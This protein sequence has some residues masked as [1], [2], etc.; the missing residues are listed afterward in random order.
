MGI[1]II[2]RISEN[3]SKNPELRAVVDPDGSELSYGQLD[4][5]SRKIAHRLVARGVSKGDF[6]LIVLPRRKEYIAAIWGILLA[7]AA[8]VPQ[9]HDYPK[10]RIDYIRSDCASKITVDEQFLRRIEEEE[11]LTDN[12]ELE[13]DDAG[14]LIYT[15]GSTGK[16][17]GVLHTLDS[18]NDA[19][20]RYDAAVNTYEGYRSGLGAPFTFI[21]SSLNILTGLYAGNTLFVTPLDVVRDPVALADHIEDN[22]IQTIFISPKI[23]KVF[24]PKGNSLELVLTGSERVSNI[25][26]DRFKT[27]VAFGMTEVFAAMLFFIDK[28]YEDTPLGKPLGDMRVYLLDD[29][30][31]RTD[32]GEICLT[33]R[34]AK[35][36][37]HLPE[38]S[39][40]TFTDNPF[41]GED[42][43]PR[44]LRTGD[45]GRYDED[46][47]VIFVNRKDWMVKINGQRVEPGE[48]EA[49]IRE[50]DSIHDVAIKDFVNQY[51]QTY[52]VAYYVEKTPVEPADIR[53]AI[54]E[55]LPSYMVPTF[56]VKLDKLPVNINGKLD[57]QALTA[58]DNS[59]FRNEYVAPE[60]D[61]TRK[62][63]SAME[64][65]LGIDRVGT[66]DD[67]L[68]MG[69]DSITATMV[70][71]KCSGYHVGPADILL[72]K[73]PGQI[74]KRILSQSMHKDRQRSSSVPKIFPLTPAERSMYLEQI[75]DRNNIMYNL[76]IMF[77]F[78]GVDTDTICRSLNEVFAA[79]QSLHS[80]YGEEGGVPVR[81][82]SEKLPEITVSEAGSEEE[83]RAVV[84]SYDVPF[85]LSEEIPVRPMLYK[86]PG[87]RHALHLVIH[88]IAFDGGS[89]KPF[90]A[91]LTAALKGKVLDTGRT[92]LSDLYEELSG[93][94]NEE[95]MEFYRKLFEGGV[96][97]N[98]MP[99][100]GGKRP[101]VHPVSDR[102]VTVVI[103]GDEIKEIDNCARRFSV[104]EFELLFSAVAAVVAKY[105]VSE[106]V[107]LGIPT[108]MRPSDCTDVI[109]MFVNTAPVR[110][111][112]PRDMNV[113][114]YLAGVREAVRQATYGSSLPFEEIVKEFAG[115]KDPSR[116]PLFDVSVNY[117]WSPEAY[118][119]NGIKC[120]MYAPLQ[121]MS[122]DIGVTMHKRREDLTI[123]FQYSTELFEDRVISDLIDQ[124]R[125]VLANFPGMPGAT[126]RSAMQL[127]GNLKAELDK[128]K[129]TALAEVPVTLLHELFEKTAEENSSRTALIAV[130]G[131]WTYSELNDAANRVAKNLI[132]RGVSVGDSVALLLPREKSFFACLIGVNKAGA[133]FIPCDP[134]YPVD[135]ISHIISDS[136]ARFVV[137]TADHIGD[138]PAEQAILVDS[139]LTL[140]DGV[141]CGNPGIQIS[142]DELSYMIYTSGSTGKPKGVMLRH[143]G[144]C[145]YLMPHPANIHMHYLREH[146]NTY[147]SVTTVSFDMSFKEHMA[148]L[149]NGKT[150]V[151]AGE[152]QMNDPRALADLLTKY[153]CDCMNA[154]PSRLLQYIEYQPFCEALKGCKL[155]MSGGEGYPMSLAERLRVIAPSARIINT[156]GPTEITVSCNGADITEAS[157]ITVGRPLLNYSELIVDKFGDI[158]PYGV[159]GELYVGGIGVARGYKNLDDMTRERFVMMDGERMYKTGDLT[160]WTSDGEVEILGRLDNQVKLR[161]LRIELG[162]IEGLLEQ[163]PSIRKAVVVIRKI[164]DQ[165]NLCAYFVSDSEEKIDIQQ[166]RE[167]LKKSL[168]PYMIPTAYLQMKELPLT[169]N[170]KTDIKSL[171]EPEEVV[172]GEYV[173]PVGEIEE[174]FCNLFAEVLRL[175]KVG[176][177]DDFFEIGGT[178]LVVTSIAVRASERGY[179]LNYGDVFKFTT[180]RQLA[181]LFSKDTAVNKNEGSDKTTDFDHYDY[182]AINE[183]LSRNNLTS[184][185]SGKHRDIGNILITGAT[186]FM[187]AHV[188]A[189]FLRNEKGK[190]YCMLRKGGFSDAA[191]RLQNVMFYYFDS[192][193]KELIDERVIVVEGDVTQYE[194]FEIFEKYP[195][196][197]VFNCAANVKHF[198]AGTDIED[199]NVGGVEKCIRFCEKT[200]AR[201][202]HFS[203][204]SVG[205]AQIVPDK[206]DLVLLD[207]Q[208]LYFGQLLDNQY[209]SSKMLAER[210]VLEAVADG[211]VDAK[212][213]R[214]GTLAPRD[215]D[216][217]FQINYLS[218][219][220]MGRLRSFWMLGA[221]PYSSMN[222]VV[223][224]G[225]IDTS[226]SAFF[227]L[228][229]TPSD[230]TVFN[231]INCNST[232]LIN[233]ILEM[234]KIGMNIELMEDE[235]F[236]ATLEQA[237]QDPDKVQVL[238]SLLAYQNKRAEKASYLTEAACVY[239]NQI[240]AREGFFWNITDGPYI[241]RFV[242]SLEALGFFDEDSL[243][244]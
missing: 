109:G 182:T 89:A 111:K 156:Y 204:T 98:D 185:K 198:S 191:S 190:A 229:T 138:Y 71:V 88:H 19:V 179:T 105:T 90:M 107:V 117:M 242:N 240:L 192:S 116:N 22:R 131:E 76:N 92:D 163:Q 81:I 147:L 94:D 244:R 15:S 164:H 222:N 174:F 135:R 212:V 59:E 193:L 189:E 53:S 3:V 157:M 171:P 206:N 17:K 100:K 173:P 74:E 29:D 43:N 13:P 132:D 119:E 186:G 83:V 99:V 125:T 209:I 82:L 230:C 44:M 41:S 166:L 113:S 167:E 84:E 7:G 87:G 180:P 14:L 123:I 70:A 56:F 136:G 168:T 175:D 140:E 161:G 9:S 217:E 200:G 39:A 80:F 207:E 85:V 68:A 188:L 152:D 134:Q 226:V 32:K 50:M 63:C 75:R 146:V 27:V 96:P 155:I 201:L 233:I 218:N 65:V 67:F 227:K 148:A 219:S 127:N 237:E 234:K 225:P 210:I 176:A 16:P 35:E 72:G 228:A 49:V 187:G 223:R 18:I 142:D 101:L 133:A 73:T 224:M 114:D 139:L 214:V 150:L 52:L 61:L 45:I 199:I 181:E 79:H 153:G 112:V 93:S 118:D 177:C 232:S 141:S 126:L 34:F 5:L 159:A 203:T 120:E 178:S 57:R 205:G 194:P 62:L 231:A 95:G 129:I 215:S 213:I 26:S 4:E 12:V 241:E 8:Y 115:E 195:I 23:L 130:D 54:S 25:Y 104:T 235:Q 108:N 103:S 97:V 33:G 36:Y 124:F 162:E 31:N 1:Q 208:T 221:F 37:Y 143:K 165:D 197:T 21:V 58:P 102:E 211:R 106:D 160:R 144:I 122:R 10:E 86:L 64:E 48:I 243:E 220:F 77:T 151:F 69:G 51:D 2:S 78:E 110:I 236:A 40:K 149:C 239:T 184:Y 137:T 28:A 238:Q 38:Q 121:K 183:V 145:S 60:T 172:V 30:G 91:D 55:R 170:G 202:I 66:A 128:F 216:G 154:T 11:L 24:E 42:N 47:N 6:V 169:P 20:I 158:A 196:D 46:G